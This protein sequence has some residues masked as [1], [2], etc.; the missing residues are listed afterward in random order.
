MASKPR[1]GAGPASVRPMPGTMGFRLVT[2]PAASAKLGLS[3]RQAASLSEAQGSI[4]AVV[5]VA[6]AGY[7]PNHVTV[8]SRIDDTLFTAEVP[9]RYLPDLSADGNVVSLEVSQTLRQQTPR[10]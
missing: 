10:R 1:T 2:E 6:T 4:L 3:A 9:A 7:V 8:R 5:R